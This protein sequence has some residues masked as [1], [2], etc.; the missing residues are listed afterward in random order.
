MRIVRI[1]AI[2]AH[3]IPDRAYP[4]RSLDYFDDLVDTGRDLPVNDEY[5][6]AEDEGHSNLEPGATAQNNYRPDKMYRCRHCNERVAAVN[7]ESHVCE[8]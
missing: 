3:Y 4:A 6:P 5:T 8:V 2:Q 1:N 7:L